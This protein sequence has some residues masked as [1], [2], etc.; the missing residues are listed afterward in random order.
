MAELEYDPALAGFVPFGT[1][2][3]A[4]S[5]VAP[6]AADNLTVRFTTSFTLPTNLAAASLTIGG[7]TGQHP[8]VTLPE[9]AV[10][11]AGVNVLSAGTLNLGQNLAHP[12]A[13]NPARLLSDLTVAKGGT[14]L[15]VDGQVAGTLTP[16]G[17][18][19]IRNNATLL[20][21]ATLAFPSLGGPLGLV[22]EATGTLTIGGTLDTPTLLAVLA[23]QDSGFNPLF[24]GSLDFA[25]TLDNSAALLPLGSL[26]ALQVTGATIHGGTLTGGLTLANVTLDGVALGG[27]VTAAAG[28][29]DTITG[30]IG[31]FGTLA[32]DG[33]LAL[34]GAVTL[35]PA[36]ISVGAGGTLLGLGAI[37]FTVAPDSLITFAGPA[38]VDFSAGADVT[39]AGTLDL[40][41]NGSPADVTWSSPAGTLTLT[42]ASVLTIGAGM[43]LAVD[44]AVTDSGTITLPGG[45]LALAGA[46]QLDTIAFTATGATL[47]LGT[48]GGSVRLV[49][50]ADG[51]RLLFSAAADIGASVI[52]NDDTLDIIGSDGTL[53]GHFTLLRTDGQHYTAGDFNLGIEGDDLLVSTTGVAVTACFASGGLID[54]AQGR[55]PV[56]TLTCGDHVR[57]AD[58]TLR[59][60]I[61]T[62]RRTVRL[63]GHPRPQDVN[64]VR[65]SANAFGPGLPARDLVLSPDHAVH[66]EA[67]LIPIRYLLNGATIA[68]ES[69]AAITYHHLEL[70][71]HDVILAEGLPCETYLDTGNRN[72]FEGGDTLLLHPAFARAIWHERGC[73]PLLTGGET[74]A[75]V[76]HTLRAQAIAL[77]YGRTTDPA[78]TAHAT[79]TG[80][81]LASRAF[82]PSHTRP[83]S[84][85]HRHLGLAITALWLDD[86]PVPLDDPRL[87]LGWHPPEPGWRW[88]GGAASIAAP[89]GTKLRFTHAATGAEYWVPP[90]VDAPR[91]PAKLHPASR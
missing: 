32:V 80:H 2:P 84:D 77:G 25:G 52:I 79:P 38:T 90:A 36:T 5:T 31:G 68:Q 70:A 34:T 7:L 10:F 88:T 1:V 24:N 16:I 17:R 21:D 53:D 67:A 45:T 72:A 8:A 85:D 4:G 14:V 44:A 46:A 58:G 82:T 83:D 37:A 47:S 59:P 9:G 61:W 19:D 41:S 27:S 64:P 20:P 78:A 42:A 35:D 3:T 33:T 51:S 12:N 60:L 39:I 63:A 76:R 40:P 26:G 11:A 28:S 23:N 71:T 50:F 65:I 62:G 18:V 15:I 87:G 57:T 48:R 73:A 6:T 91:Y 89:P 13:A 43:R 30:T 81:I 56:E 86:T 66:V 69:R 55:R 22:T 74:V 54:T 29:H 75:L 49:D